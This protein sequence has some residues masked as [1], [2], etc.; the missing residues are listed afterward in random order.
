MLRRL[1]GEDS[2]SWHDL[3]PASGLGRWGHARV[4]PA[5]GAGSTGSLGAMFDHVTIRAADRGATERFYD[6]VLEPLGISKSHSDADG[7]MWED[8]GMY[9]VDGTHPA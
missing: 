6:T 8:L 1:S 2:S 4:A 5:L 9:A 3:A 7:A